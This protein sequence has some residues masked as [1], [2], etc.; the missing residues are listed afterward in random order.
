MPVAGE[1]LSRTPPA[2]Y[3]PNRR[4]RSRATPRNVDN[5]GNAD[6]ATMS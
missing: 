3:Q 4:P 6:N 5:A 2:P 1:T